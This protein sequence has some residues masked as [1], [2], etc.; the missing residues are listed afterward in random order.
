MPDYVRFKKQQEEKELYARLTTPWHVVFHSFREHRKIE[1]LHENANAANFEGCDLLYKIDTLYGVTQLGY[2]P[3]RQQSFLFSNIKT[4]VYDN[5][6]SRYMR[7]LQE[8]RMK[9]EQKAGNENIIFNSRKD[10]NSASLLFKAQTSPWTP[11]SVRPYLRRAEQGAL[12]KTM[13]FL[14]RSEELQRRHEVQAEQRVCAM[15]E[16]QDASL[17]AQSHALLRESEFLNSVLW[18]KQAL[19]HAF[20]RKINYAFDIQKQEMFSYYKERREQRMAALE[21]E[22]EENPDEEAAH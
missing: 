21:N 11:S 8:L 5:A 22:A 19:E 12:R 4:S 18:R 1:G 9:R 10:S 3:R 13:P 14:S 20:F 17:R 2:S 16:K 7:E 15:T 6:A